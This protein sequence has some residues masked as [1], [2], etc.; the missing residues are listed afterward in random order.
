MKK[1]GLIGTNGFCRYLKVY[2]VVLFFG[3]MLLS[4]TVFGAECEVPDSTHP[5]TTAY[6]GDNADGPYST[7]TD[8]IADT[9]EGLVWDADGSKLTDTY[10]FENACYRCEQ[11]GGGW[12]LPT[13]EELESLVDNDYAPVTINDTYFTGEQLSYW[14]ASVPDAMPSAAFAV[15]FSTGHTSALSKSSPGAVRCVRDSESATSD[16]I[17]DIALSDGVGI[18]Y[19]NMVQNSTTTPFFVVV[20]AAPKDV[21]NAVYPE[22]AS[23]SG[24]FWYLHVEG[25]D[26]DGNAID[27]NSATEGLTVETNNAHDSISDDDKVPV[28]SNDLDVD[29]KTS[30]GT[31]GLTADVD[32]SLLAVTPNKEGV[33][34]FT[35]TIWYQASG[36]PTLK[37][38]DSATIVICEGDCV[39]E[40]AIA[41]NAPYYALDT[42]TIVIPTLYVT[43]KQLTPT[44]KNVMIETVGLTKGIEMEL[45]KASGNLQFEMQPFSN[46]TGT[47]ADGDGYYAGVGIGLDCNDNDPE[48]NPGMVEVYNDN[49]DNDCDKNTYDMIP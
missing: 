40:Q 25:I 3:L 44:Y 17:F 7:V 5:L 33:Y 12:R 35:L 1:N 18:E 49:I 45:I 41:D 48:V 32:T 43:D 26:S 34:T 14:S 4:S 47:D 38:S 24:Y 8:G 30:L 11:L 6:F 19:T 15:D 28:Y 23:T 31:Y 20:K 39:V 37:G 46:L 2:P 21:N 22:V 36:Y 16:L 9:V 13:I 42:Q 29:L 10:D 27:I